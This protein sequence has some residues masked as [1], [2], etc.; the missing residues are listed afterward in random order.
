MNYLNTEN[1]SKK[2]QEKIKA[3]IIVVNAFVELIN[4]NN[5]NDNTT[6]YNKFVGDLNKIISEIR[7]KKTIDMNEL[8]SLFYNE[9]RQDEII[10][11]FKDNDTINISESLAELKRVTDAYSLSDFLCDNPLLLTG[12]ALV[13]GVTLTLAILVSPGVAFSVLMVGFIIGLHC[14]ATSA[15]DIIR[16]LKDPLNFNEGEINEIDSINHLSP[17]RETLSGSNSAFFQSIS[18]DN[19]IGNSGCE[20]EV[21]VTVGD[22]SIKH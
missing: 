15:L 20:S 10:N 7:D 11:L 14:L 16:M 19:V 2:E 21:S 9:D 13:T 4:K 1:R 8:T 6:E 5:S 12:A 18:G 17:S 22:S 3:V